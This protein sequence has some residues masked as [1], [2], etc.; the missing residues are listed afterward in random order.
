M[1]NQNQKSLYHN[2]LSSAQTED[3]QILK[4]QA[5]TLFLKLTQLEDKLKHYSKLKK[6]NKFKNIPQ[7]SKYS[8]AILFAG[9]DARLI[10]LPNIDITLT[11][12]NI[13]VTLIV[14]GADVLEDSFVTV[15]INTYDKNCKHFTKYLDKMYLFKQDTLRGVIDANKIE[16]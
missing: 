9:I 14:I 13:A 11:I 10:Y 16:Q 5:D 7:Y 12:I 1:T 8:V 15:K 6:Y 3:Q 4:L 2:L